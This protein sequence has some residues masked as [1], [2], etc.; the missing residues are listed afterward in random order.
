[1]DSNQQATPKLSESDASARPLPLL[2]MELMQTIAP[3]VAAV[4]GVQG[5]P[6]S[7]MLAS[8]VASIGL[9]GGNE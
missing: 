1:M 6:S 7:L 3:P 9:D 5:F 4:S 8:T 2:R